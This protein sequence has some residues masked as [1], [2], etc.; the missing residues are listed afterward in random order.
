MKS[1]YVAMAILIAFAAST[2]A[3][4]GKLNC[5]LA[6]RTKMKSGKKKM[7]MLEVSATGRDDCKQQAR[8]RETAPHDDDVEFVKVTFSFR[9]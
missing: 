8:Q 5:R 4:E 1:I 9:N 7:E 2:F 6:V 3:D